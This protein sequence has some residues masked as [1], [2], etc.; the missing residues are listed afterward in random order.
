MYKLTTLANQAKLI[1][2]PMAGAKTTT[3]LVMF[4][5]G[6]KFETTANNGIS[7]FLEHMF[8]K[9]TTKRPNTMDISSDLDKVG[10]DFNAFTSKEYTG[11]WVKAAS[12]HLPLALDVVSDMLLHSKFDQAE[13]D[14][15]KGVII[16]EINMYADNPRAYIEVLFEDCLY[17][18]QPAGR[19]V[20]GPKENIRKFTRQD[21]IKY[22][23]SQYGSNSAY[24]V[25][26]GKVPT[27]VK[28][29]VNKYFGHLSPNNYQRKIKTKDQ[30]TKAQVKL[31]YKKT[32]QAHLLLGVRALPSGHKDESITRALAIVLGGS[33]SSRLFT[34][35]RERHG[36]CYYVR[37]SNERYS[38]TGYIATQAG[39]PVNKID[40]AIKIIIAEYS[41]ITK[42]GLSNDELNKVKNLVAGR[43]ALQMEASD[44][45]AI[46]YAVQAAILHQQSKAQTLIEPEQMVQRLKKVTTAQIQAMAKKIFQ[47]NQLNLA[48]IGPYKD[49][50]KFKKLLVLK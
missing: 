11:Y 30:Q 25:I 31:H 5:T 12:Q 50:A 35:L 16:E 47:N 37:T 1:T 22:W 3:V 6:A 43:T 8:F 21:F 26:A 46:W 33:M 32:D 24:I 29:L 48:I 41:R 27:N 20:L 15:E 34:Q 18:E 13:I 49:T 17:G 36:L 2:I 39:V 44:D 10:A 40:Q 45:L 4:A 38:D 42:Q 7:H 9:G 19:S 14:R 23:Q 28:T